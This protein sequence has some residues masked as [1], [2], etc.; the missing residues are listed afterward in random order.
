MEL[1]DIEFL[2]RGV[3]VPLAAAERDGR[4]AVGGEP[5]G[6]QAAVG[7]GEFGFAALGLDR[8]RGR[9]DARLVAA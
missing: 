6:V 1:G 7:D 9:G 5:I 2:A 3:D 8:R 4:N